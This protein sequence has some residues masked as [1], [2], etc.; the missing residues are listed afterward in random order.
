MD[1]INKGMKKTAQEKVVSGACLVRLIRDVVCFTGLTGLLILPRHTLG[2]TIPVAEVVS[3]LQLHIRNSSNEMIT[4]NAEWPVDFTNQLEIFTATNLIEGNWLLAGSS[5]DTER[6]TNFNMSLPASEN[7]Q[8]YLAAIADMDSDGDGLSDA[9]ETLLFGSDPLAEDT[10][11]DGLLDGDD[12]Y[13]TVSG[14]MININQPIAGAL[15][16]NSVVTVS[17]SILFTGTVHSVLVG[18]KTATLTTNSTGADFS[19]TIGFADDGSRI[20]RIL[21]VGERDGMTLEG[22]KQR[23]ITI[24]ARPPRL[25]VIAPSSGETVTGLYSH[26]TIQSDDS[27][28]VLINEHE[29]EQDGFMNLAWVELQPGSNTITIESMDAVGRTT[30]ELLELYCMVPPGYTEDPPSDSDEDGVLDIFDYAPFDA[31]VRTT[32]AITSHAN[33]QEIITGADPDSLASSRLITLEGTAARAGSVQLH[34]RGLNGP[35]G[36]DRFYS[37]AVDASGFYRRQVELY[38]G[39]NIITVSAGSQKTKCRVTLRVDPPDVKIIYTRSSS[40][41]SDS[42]SVHMYR[43]GYMRGGDRDKL[44]MEPERYNSVFTPGGDESYSWNNVE[45]IEVPSAKPGIYDLVLEHAPVSVGEPDY[46]E[47]FGV[48]INGQ[49]VDIVLQTVQNY[50]SVF[51]YPMETRMSFGIHSG[52]Y[53]GAFITGTKSCRELSGQGEV[54]GRGRHD[55]AYDVIGL[56]AARVGKNAFVNVGESMRI[57]DST[58]LLDP[59]LSWIPEGGWPNIIEDNTLGCLGLVGGTSSNA[60]VDMTG[61]FTAMQSGH[62]QVAPVSDAGLVNGPDPLDIYVFDPPQ[63]VPDYDRDGTIDE[64]DIALADSGEPFR[65]WINDDDDDPNSEV[66]G[67][68][69]PDSGNPDCNSQTI[70]GMRDLIDFF[71]VKIE[72]DEIL[73]DTSSFSYYLVHED[74]AVKFAYTQMTDTNSTQFFKDVETAQ[75]LSHAEVKLVFPD[76]GAPPYDGNKLNDSVFLSRISSDHEAV[77]L[78]EG[79]STTTEPLIFE[80][81]ESSSGETVASAELNLSIS[82]VEQMYR[83]INLRGEC[84]GAVGRSTDADE[85]SRYSDSICNGKQFV[86]VHGFNVTE[87]AARGS[88][89]EVFKR[90]FW[91]GSSAMYTVVTW[92]GNETPGIL[93]AGAYYHA[94]VINAFQTA[95]FLAESIASLPGEKYLAAHSLGNM[96]ASS[97]IVDDELEVEKYFMIDAAVAM[98]AYKASEVQAEE[99]AQP[100]S[101]LSYPNRLWA[102]EWYK[103]FD[104][105]DGRFGLTWH[106]RFGNIPQAINYYSSGEDVLANNDPAENMYLPGND[107]AWVFQEKVKGGIMPAI[108]VGV[109][110]QG[111]WKYNSFYD[112]QVDEDTDGGL[113]YGTMPPDQATLLSD[114]QLQANSFFGSFYDDDLYGPDGSSLASNEYVRAKVLAEAV[115]ATSRA[116][117]RNPVTLYFGTNRD[118]MGFK[119]GWPSGRVAVNNE[120][121]WF[122][123]DFK[124]VAY[125][126]VYLFF[127]DMVLKG[128]LK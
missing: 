4:V 110:S 83:W 6:S 96:V 87:E 5:I 73:S 37:A 42:W 113:V 35:W 15:L 16:T 29:A 9:H 121:P 102:S 26:L 59:F 45:I 10:D 69:V 128:G 23:V 65:F 13:P 2:S 30:S 61:C 120:G 68:D 63:L 92:Y 28:P 85:P 52:E 58:R 20:I 33:G 101:W 94:D 84:G 12:D 21:A 76:L 86:F 48:F 51:P 103:L 105:S 41:P 39:P 25:Q 34:V 119:D 38:P 91:A 75:S 64:K 31:T 127:N 44:Y 70:D 40:L 106:G 125:T 109:D 56:D 55:S 112:V 107:K 93:P 46:A 80:I 126:Y 24:D 104:P 27:A 111:G 88:G 89:A 117:G 67:N 122:H 72:L 47:T 82:G 14:P 1:L 97:A 99:I 32:V 77:L 43:Y 18:P 62:Y 17:G 100:A 115:P 36:T 116:T 74:A 7:Q 11:G 71:P 53:A 81:R 118:L 95:P 50:G 66:Y 98:Q 78:L 114:D 8:F 124:N 108:L 79:C 19:A 90:L 57:A 54:V 49:L 3:N 123:S 60:F 22:F